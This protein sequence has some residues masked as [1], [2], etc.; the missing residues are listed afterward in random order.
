MKMADKNFQERAKDLINDVDDSTSKFDKKEID[1]GKG[2]GVL[3]YIIPLI[4]FFVEKKNKFVMYHAK[5]GM[6]LFILAIGYSIIYSILTSVIKVKGSCGY[7][8][9]GALAYE[10][11]Y[12]C[13]V[14][15][16]W[17]I[18]PLS[19]IGL[20]ISI[21]CIMGIYNVCKGRAKDLPIVSKIK[22]FK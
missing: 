12:A 16:W 5:Q 3:S 4:P 15:P 14:T 9:W 22:I 8:S 11:G 6:N 2:M 20:I 13:K 21:L 1:S 18:L 10:M 17:V 19:L 7:G